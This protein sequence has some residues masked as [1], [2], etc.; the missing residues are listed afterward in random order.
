[1]TIITEINS[2]LQLKKIRFWTIIIILGLFIS[3]LTAIP[4]VLETR[5]LAHNHHLFPEILSSWI[6][7]VR[8]GISISFSKY[9]FLAYGTDWL[10]FAHFMFAVLFLGVYINP[11]QNTWIVQFGIVA[12]LSLIPYAFLMGYFREIPLVWR[13]VDSCFGLLGCIPLF[14]I[15]RNI[16]K[17]NMTNDQE[18]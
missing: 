16:N 12:C 17:L 18:L 3:G 7:Y 8:E 2:E 9:P 1:M 4:L 10:A 15:Y 5:I 6:L 13:F 14:I 11:V